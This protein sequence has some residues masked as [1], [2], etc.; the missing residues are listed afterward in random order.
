MLTLP[1]LVG[2]V[3]RVLI[4]KNG[5]I[6]AFV[7]EMITAVANMASSGEGVAVM[8][9]PNH[10]LAKLTEAGKIFGTQ[11]GMINPVNMDDVGFANSLMFGDVFSPERC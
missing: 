5:T 6:A 9:C 4:L 7:F 2:L 3:V 8:E 1:D 11:E 10:R